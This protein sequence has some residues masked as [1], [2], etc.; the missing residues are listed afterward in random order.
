MSSEKIAKETAVHIKKLIILAYV[1]TWALMI[2]RG[3]ATAGIV[4]QE[5]IYPTKKREKGTSLFH[6]IDLNTKETYWIV[7]RTNKTTLS[8][9]YSSYKHCAPR[10]TVCKSIIFPGEPVGYIPSGLVHIDEPC[11]HSLSHVGYINT[12]GGI[13]YSYPDNHTFG[14]QVFVSG[15]MLVDIL[16][17]S[18]DRDTYLKIWHTPYIFPTPVQPGGPFLPTKRF[19]VRQHQTPNKYLFF[20]YYTRSS[21]VPQPS[22]L[23][24]QVYL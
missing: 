20:P 16:S 10:C 19:N 13:V 3:F 24:M 14:Q 11:S 7:T 22:G 12:E 4:V 17:P 1:F 9:W 2:K 8:A 21:P 15:F 5:L 18:L 23:H 6:L